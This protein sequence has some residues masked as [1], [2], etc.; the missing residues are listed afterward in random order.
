MKGKN[1]KEIL[2]LIKNKLIVSCQ[3]LPDEPLHSP[4]I[5]G[6]MAYAAYLGGAGGIR[7]NGIEDIREIKKNVNLPIIGII[8][9]EYAGS[10]VYITPTEKE[11][12]LLYNEGVEIIAMDATKRIRP[13]GKS[14]S[15]V[16]P[17]IRQKYPDQVFMADCSC[18]EEAKEAYR[19]GFDCIGTTLCGYTEYT[20]HRPKPDLEFIERLVKDFEVPII[21]EGGIWTPEEVK[22]IF[23]L[24]V[25]A[26]VV[27]TAITRPQEITKRFVKAAEEAVN[28][29]EA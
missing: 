28:K 15:E 9:K 22:K 10:D 14:I 4:F 19:L 26:V 24:G 25:Y 6:K 3:A 21:A 8:K 27:G 13:D 29:R 7:A 1:K 20:K 2:N 18:Y 12:D 5:M 17:K 11:V 23:S 16:F